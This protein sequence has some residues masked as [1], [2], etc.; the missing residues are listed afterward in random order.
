MKF[1]FNTKIMRFHPLAEAVDLIAKAGFQAVELMADRPHA[2]PRDLNAERISAL[3]HCLAERK[4]QVSNLNSATVVSLEEPHN[5]SWVDEDWQIRE[6]RLRYTLDC[7][8]LAAAIGVPQ[9]ST[10][11]A[12]PIP[13]GS[14]YRESFRLFVAI[15]HRVL[16]LARKLGVRLL[17]EPTPGMLIENSD[18]LLDLMAE[19]DFSDFLQVSF[20]NVHF[21]LAGENPLSAWERLKD[22]V[23]LVRLSDTT[24]QSP[25]THLVLGEGILD[26][27]AFLTAVQRS[28]FEGYVT[29]QP[30]GNEQRADMVVLGAAAYLQGAG[31][32][33][34]GG[35]TPG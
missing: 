10:Q 35:E 27:P 34:G 12:G 7:L 24:D 14:T 17:I 1:S 5:P 23:S 22:H 8:R 15:L 21:H 16:P 2:F 25:H 19:L 33:A 30:E 31:F 20:D 18:H 9:V 4:L 3:N 26:L 6:Q 32:M 28:G 11:G 13:S 29:I